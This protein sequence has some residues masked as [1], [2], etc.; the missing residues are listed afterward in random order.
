MITLLTGAPGNGKSLFLIHMV[1]EWAKKE[2]RPVFYA[3][4]TLTE[5]GKQ[6]LGWTEIEATKWNECPPGAI[7]VTDECQTIYRNRSI[8][9]QA[10]KYV[11]DLETH[12]HLGIDLVY[13]TQ[14]PMLIDPALRRLTGKHMHCIRMWG[15]Q[16]SVIHEWSQVRENCDK[17]A[18]RKDSIKHQFVFDKSI[19]GLYKSAELHTMKRNIPMR[20]KMIPV[21][22]LL[23]AGLV[24]LIY[25][26]MMKRINPDSV[27]VVSSQGQA[28]QMP[29]QGGKTEKEFDPVADARKYVF[30][31]TPRVTGLLHT[32]PKYDSLTEPTVVPV[33]AVC[34]LTIDRCKCY[35]QQATP[36]AV[37]HDLCIDFAK[38]GYFQEFNP[39]GE[40]AER[41]ARQPHEVSQPLERK[42]ESDRVESNADGYGVL[43]KAGPGVRLPG[44][45]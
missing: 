7:I 38:N 44:Q 25:G 5:T 34:V 37:D 31:Q 39:D 18:A 6:E 23:L 8:N 13:V 30:M 19:Y 36:L 1:R 4:I 20:V 27:E 3:G 40:R 29:G 12:R 11:T 10:P 35:T 28:S 9:A 32:A 26:S 22:C 24:Y 41:G 42:T 43:G 16:K 14:H 45:I 15:M 33:P 21:L 17:P 2:N